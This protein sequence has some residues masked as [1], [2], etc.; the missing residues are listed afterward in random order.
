M[1][2]IPKVEIRHIAV[3]AI[4]KCI[5]IVKVG[6]FVGASLFFRPAVEIGLVVDEDIAIEDVGM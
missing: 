1:T 6:L 2:K 5:V 4:R 3:S